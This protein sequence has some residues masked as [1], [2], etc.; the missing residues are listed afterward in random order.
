MELSVVPVQI[1][2]QAETQIEREGTEKDH[3]SSTHTSCRY[4]NSALKIGFSYLGFN[5]KSQS[6]V[7]V[8]NKHGLGQNEVN[9][10]Y[11]LVF[12]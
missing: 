10:Y 3:K 7:V 5:L 6:V 8:A 11:L 12:L 9:L 2:R 4:Y 1:C